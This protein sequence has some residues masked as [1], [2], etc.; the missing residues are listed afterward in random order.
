MGTK[1]TLTSPQ[2]LTR[3]RA[4]IVPGEHLRKASALTYT[5]LV[6]EESLEDRECLRLIRIVSTRV[7]TVG[8]HHETPWLTHWTLHRIALDDEDAEEVARAFQ[9]DLDSRHPNAWYID[10]RNDEWH[11]II[12]KSR[13]FRVDRE[14][15]AEYQAVRRYGLELGIPDGQLDF[16]P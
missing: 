16:I 4:E 13:I 3:L 10:F 12:F 15:L 2:G 9:R 14:N 5:G 1:L 8:A 11:Y 6:I 7:E